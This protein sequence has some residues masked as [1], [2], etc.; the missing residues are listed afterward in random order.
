MWL[1]TDLFWMSV[2]DGVVSMSCDHMFSSGLAPRGITEGPSIVNHVL[3][4]LAFARDHVIAFC[5]G[6]LCQYLLF[7]YCS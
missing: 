3:G 7:C 5:L 1:N 2:V 4:S 6:G